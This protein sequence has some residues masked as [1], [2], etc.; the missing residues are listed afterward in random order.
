M[1]GSG[2]AQSYL[3]PLAVRIQSVRMGKEGRGWKRFLVF[4]ELTKSR[5]GADYVALFTFYSFE[6]KQSIPVRRI[7]ADRFIAWTRIVFAEGPRQVI[8]ALT[9]YSVLQAD[10]IP[11]GK[12]APIHGNSPVAQFFDNIGSLASKNREQAVVLFGMLWTLVIWVISAIS[13]AVSLVLYLL[14]LFHHIPSEDGGLGNYCRRKINRRMERIIKAKVDKALKKEDTLRVRQEAK[15]GREIKRQPTL[16]LFDDVGEL[17]MPALSRQPTQSTLPEYTSRDGSDRTSAESLSRKPTLPDVGIIAGRPPPLTR[18][19]THASSASWTTYASNAP[20]VGEAASMG[21]SPSAGVQ[22]PASATSAGWPARPP[23]SRS[24]T[25]MSQS[26]QR[27]YTAGF[28][29][30]SSSAQGDRN[31]PGTYPMEPLSRPGTGMSSGP[32]SSGRRGP[33]PSPG[34]SQGRRTPTNQYNP[35]FPAVPESGRNT[36]IDSDTN[37]P[38]SQGGRMPATQNNSYYPSTVESGRQSPGPQSLIR[39]QTPGGT[40]PPPRS[41]TP[42]G[43]RSVTPGSQSVGSEL[44]NLPRLQT[45]QNSNNSGYA[46]YAPNNYSNTPTSAAPPGAYRSFTQPNLSLGMPNYSGRQTPQSSQSIYP[47]QRSGTAPLPQR[48]NTH[49][50][51]MD[52]IVNGYR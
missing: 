17:S 30:R 11:A 10:L 27:S 34:E 3:D 16:P 2:V 37:Q 36:P 35:Y 21:Y 38:N 24:M 1:K 45:A 51:L 48:Q 52:D 50:D 43:S 15:E 22:A 49:D 9:L 33:R 46:A 42:G 31:A 4:A 44:P 23:P 47:P 39:S 40:M 29:T 28:G 20:L 19:A 5:K 25:G 14:F 18:T 32:G 26:T 13:L 8:N 7:A 41:F 12:H 6:G